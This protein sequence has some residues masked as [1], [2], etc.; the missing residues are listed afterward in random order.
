MP[1]AGYMG[2]LTFAKL[3]LFLLISFTNFPYFATQKA[4]KM[5]R[6]ELVLVI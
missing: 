5:I 4:E 3:V 2:M 1:L 6:S